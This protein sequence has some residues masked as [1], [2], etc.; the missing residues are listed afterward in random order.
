MI[1]AIRS[2]R[3]DFKAVEFQ[4]G[5]N[6]ILAER[7]LESTR[8][9][10]RNGLGKTTLIEIIHFCLGGST[11]KGKGLRQQP[12]LGWTFSIEID[13]RGRPYTIHRN[14]ENSGRVT[15]EGD[16][17]DWPIRPNTDT[18]RGE[19]Y[20]SIPDWNTVLGWLVFDLPVL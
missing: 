7:T 12:L 15:I 8:K 1:R 14:T 13:L 5:F 6:V 4:P 17:S 9:D 16:W 18:K 11:E 19:K 3:P 20:L 2:D 10:S